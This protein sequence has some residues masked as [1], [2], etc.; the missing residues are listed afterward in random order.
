MIAL[1]MFSYFVFFCVLSLGC[2][3]LFIIISASDQ[4]RL[5]YCH[6]KTTTTMTLIATISTSSVN[7]TVLMHHHRITK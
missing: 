4:T 6:I 5:L 7:T 2:Y 3:S 1:I